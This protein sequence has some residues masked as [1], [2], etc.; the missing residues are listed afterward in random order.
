MAA[1]PS[2]E[3][4]MALLSRKV[5]HFVKQ[6]LTALGGFVIRSQLP[7]TWTFKVDT[8]EF[9]FVMDRQG[10]VTRSRGLQPKADVR[11]VTTR[12]RLVAHLGSATPGEALPSSIGV[13]FGTARGRRAY[14]YVRRN[15]RI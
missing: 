15:L 2:A 3:E 5:E 7:Q 4:T 9:S 12:E 14:F 13:S 6:R 10:N 1:G 11:V 8:E